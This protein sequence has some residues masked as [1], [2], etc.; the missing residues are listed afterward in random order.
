MI[1]KII[2]LEDSLQVAMGEL[3][4]L[5][6]EIID[7]DKHSISVNGKVYT[8]DTAIGVMEK[9][10]STVGIDKLYRDKYSYRTT[11]VNGV[12]LDCPTIIN[13]KSRNFD[14]L[15]SAAGNSLYKKINGGY[16]LCSNMSNDTVYKNAV[17]L[18]RKY[19]VQF[20][21]I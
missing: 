3:Q 17:L 21:H 10:V 11:K 8:V 9:I 14:I 6:K 20:K 1:D 4:D 7:S 18:A 16:Y 19:S 15:L 2:R 5:K 13:K 12:D